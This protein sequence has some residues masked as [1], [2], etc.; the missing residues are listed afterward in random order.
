MSLIDVDK[1]LAPVSPDQPCGEN[2]EYD[3]DYAAMEQAAAGKPEQQFGDTVIPG[4]EPDWREVRAK[5]LA[6]LERTKDLRIAMHLARSATRIDGLDGLADS[7]GVLAGLVDRYWDAV[8][9]QLDPDDGNDPTIRVNTVASL[10]DGA[11]MLRFVREAPLVL[12]RGMGSFSYRDHL[13]V[14]GEL[15]PPAGQEKPDGS[16]L[17][18]AF[19]ECDGEALQAAAAAVARAASELTSL[20]SKI[21]DHVGIS[22]AP[23]LDDLTNLLRAIGKLLHEKLAARGLL[24]DALAASDGAA[25]G[26]HS[27]GDG[28]AARATASGH[29]G[30][31]TMSLTGEISSREDVIRAIDRICDYYKR[32][33]PSSPVPLFLNRAKRLASKSFLEILRD[34]TPDALNQAL[35]LG[36]ISEA[37]G[38]G[39]GGIDPDEV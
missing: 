26:A 36:G 12:A 30:G 29:N 2:L 20:E 6:L 21:T 25:P 31:S 10:C 11:T 27:N 8:H 3:A 28:I 24:A 32:Y 5:A 39:G 9:P 1:L 13:V 7:L 16:A 33:E 34:L 15:P 22:Q 37:A 19:A 17:E 18:G 23:A 4:E 14:T 35:A 38:N